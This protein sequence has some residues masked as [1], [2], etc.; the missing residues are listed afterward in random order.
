MLVKGFIE[1]VD[2]TFKILTSQQSLLIIISSV[3][4][5]NND[6]HESS[7]NVFW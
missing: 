3:V 2:G 6:F 1:V 5:K 7:S 4:D